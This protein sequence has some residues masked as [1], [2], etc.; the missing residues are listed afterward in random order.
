MAETVFRKGDHVRKYF[1]FIL[2]IF[3]LIFSGTILSSTGNDDSYITTEKSKGVF[4]L[5]ESGKSS[6]L[7]VSTG[8]YPG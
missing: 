2:L 7:L 8:D 1:I 4:T 6:P 3:L 5:S